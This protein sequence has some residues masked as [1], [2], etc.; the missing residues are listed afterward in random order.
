MGV[1]V[2]GGYHHNVVGLLA[3][4]AD[5]RV[6]DAAFP[7]PFTFFRGEDISTERSGQN[8]IDA[9]WE[10]VHGWVGFIVL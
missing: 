8:G 10:V 9:F 4:M 2:P 6:G 7:D 1:T 5:L 3:G